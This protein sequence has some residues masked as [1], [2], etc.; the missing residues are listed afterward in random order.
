MSNLKLSATVQLNFNNVEVMARVNDAVFAAT[1]DIFAEIEATAIENVPVLAADTSERYPGELR[2][3]IRDSIRHVVNQ[4]EQGV[5]ATLFTAETGSDWISKGRQ[6]AGYGGF[7]ELGTAKTPAQPFMW[8]ALE[9]HIG[10]LPDAVK[11]K[12]DEG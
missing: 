12:L 3:S 7:L 8:P 1:K 6:L 4:H 2:D 11:E 5:K 10:E 9:E